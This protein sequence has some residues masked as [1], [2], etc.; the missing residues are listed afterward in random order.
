MLGEILNSI[1]FVFQVVFWF[2]GV[3]YTI[4]SMFGLIEKFRNKKDKLYTPEK[5][6]AIFIPA[7]NEEV[8]ISGIVH[9]LKGINYPKELYDVFVVADN[10]T[11]GTAD[12][13][14]NAGAKVL[15]RFDDEDKGKGHALKWAFETVLFSRNK[16][17]KYDA[18]VIFDADN[19]V[20]KDFL[21]EMNNKLCAGHKVV[22]GFI[23]SKNPNDSWITLA[24]SV[25]FW[26]VNRL[27]QS[28]RCF[29]GLSNEIGG[30]GFCM[31]VQVLKKMGWEATSLA[32]DLE[33][34]AK[35]VLNGF[36][37]AWAPNAVIYDEKPL[38]LMQSW[39][40]RRRWM[41]GF[42]DVCSRY[43]FVLLKKGIK[44]R[45]LAAID[46]AIYTL[47][48]YVLILG[49]IMLLLPFANILF[50]EGDLFILTTNISTAFFFYVG[51]IQ[52]LLLPISL[53]VDKR[54]TMRMLLF[55]PAYAVFCLTWIPIAVEGIVKMK[56]KD[57]SHT[58][59]TRPLSIQEIE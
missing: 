50:F 19:L 57:W 55:Y 34:T 51:M 56:N 11:D 12:T 23:D 54:F 25:S 24:Y 32:E 20:A 17:Y 49:G 31:D 53:I 9:N 29:L 13:A 43:F 39:K 33:F 30:T 15:V 45:D 4:T 10:C 58:L 1:L 6:F 27:F 47:Q 2:I 22:Q 46:C 3:Y 7:H 48:P 28:A 18:A 37:V 8:V 36:K 35:L 38:T 40:Q 14:A 16:N 26:S 52:L 41:Q 5:R 59:H 21:W 42:A 44:E